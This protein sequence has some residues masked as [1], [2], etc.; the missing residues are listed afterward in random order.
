MKRRH[1]VL[2]PAAQLLPAAVAVAAT[3]FRVLHVGTYAP[4]GQGVYS[5]AIG[6]DGALKP[7][8]VTPNANSPTWLATDGQRVY[9][10]EE[11]ADH[12]AVYA[13]DEAG[14]LQLLQREPS[15][16]RGPAHLSLSAGR[17]WV[18][19]YGSAHFAALP[20][21]PDGRV[22]AAESWPSCAGAECRPGPQPAVKAPRG[23]QA[24]SGHD[25]PHAH[26]IQTSPDGRWVLG[27]DLGLDRLLAWPLTASTPSGPARELALS[28]GSGPR[29]F[30]FNPVNGSLV[31]VLQEQSST[32]STV[33]LAADGPQ[34]LDEISVLP[35][36]YA[37]TSFASDLIVAPGGRH[38]Y[39]LNRLYNSLSVISLADPR[40]PRLLDNH[41]VHGDYPRSACQVGNHL[42]VCN[43]RSDQLS[44]FDLSRP[45]APRF[46][47][48]QQPVPSPAGACSLAANKA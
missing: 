12:V 34:L 6:A 40:K 1:V 21:R 16:G 3:P 43:H 7:L 22:G 37:G 25:A 28:A 48:R 19:H 4:L 36:G 35:A 18:A 11:G 5:F 9:A 38:L 32:L 23:S 20:V 2:L 45:E 42:Y 27:T 46:T 13:Q 15:G 8:G 17:V 30:A 31:Y 26:M 14:R 24:N 29:H 41:W 47:G 44:H 39:A 33:M 10:A